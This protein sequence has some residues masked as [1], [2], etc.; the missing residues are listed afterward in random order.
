[1]ENNYPQAVEESLQKIH[2]VLSEPGGFFDEFGVDPTIGAQMIHKVAGEI[3]LKSWL[4]TGDA[5]I[6][7]DEDFGKMLARIVAYSHLENLKR[8]GLI[9][10]I[11]DSSGEE[12]VWL[13]DKGKEVAEHTKNF[14]NEL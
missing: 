3:L 13:T 14:E 11:E 4:E 10:S 2:L 7:D 8:S 9:D 5:S 1:M 6:E 12:V